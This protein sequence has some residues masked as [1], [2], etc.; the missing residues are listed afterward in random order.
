LDQSPE[1]GWNPVLRRAASQLQEYLSGARRHFDLELDLRGTPFQRRVWTQ[2]QEIPYGS[3]RSYGQVAARIGRPR[4]SRAVGAANGCN[5]VPVVVPCHR[6]IGG[7]G[8]MVGYAGGLEL[9]R[10][11]LELEG[12]AVPTHASAR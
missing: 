5:P 2:L 4:S 11:L 10:R 9:K 3:T 7:N 8:T 1:Q 6:V 12:V